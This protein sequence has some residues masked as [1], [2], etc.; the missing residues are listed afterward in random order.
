SVTQDEYGVRVDVECEAGGHG[1]ETLEAEYVIGCDGGHSLIREQAGIKRTGTN[2]D[3]LMV[4]SVFRSRE[5]NERL[6][7][8]PMRST[9]RIMNPKLNG[10][11][12]FFGRVDPDETFFVHSPV[13]NDTMRENYDFTNLMHEAAGFKFACEFEHVGFWD[14]NVSIADRYRLG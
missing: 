14:L 12:Q 7:R 9:Y 6:K 3:Q 8:F 2:F 11:W 13:P 5:F 4:L 1:R 10:Y